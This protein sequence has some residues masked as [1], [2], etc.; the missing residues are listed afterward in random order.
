MA[1]I[2]EE[3]FTAKDGRSIYHRQW[4]PTDSKKIVATVIFAHG[5]G[6]HIQ[7]YDHV[8]TAF[9]KHNIKT[10]SFDQRGFGLTGKKAGIL[11]HNETYA[12]LMNDMHECARRVA[13]PGVPHFVMGHSMGGGIALRYALNH[14]DDTDLPIAGV[15]ASAPLVGLGAKTMPSVPEYYGLRALGYFLSSFTL[16]NPVD[17]NNLSKDAKVNEAYKTDPYVHPFVSLGTVREIVMNGEALLATDH[18]NFTLP[19]LVSF[20]TGDHIC[21][22]KDAKAFFDKVV[23]KDKTFKSYDNVYHELHND[24]EKETVIQDYINWIVERANK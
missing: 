14:R 19:L 2:T 4:E 9:A 17:A 1:T 23:A 18:V 3:W 12:T 13:V 15:I 20:G 22:Y 6:E 16:N 8:F 5:V 24:L 10:R 7:R 11:G 21:S